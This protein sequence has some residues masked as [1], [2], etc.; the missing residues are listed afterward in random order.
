M[1]STASA[2]SSSPVRFALDDQGFSKALVNFYREFGGD[3]AKIIRAQARLISVNLV[4]QTQPF[5]GSR[6]TPGQQAGE[7][8]S[9]KKLGE[10]AIQRDINDLYTTPERI[11]YMIREMSLGAAKGFMAMVK[12][13][14]FLQAKALLDRLQISGLRSMDVGDFD[15]G[16]LHQARLRPVPGRPRIRKN[17]KPELIVPDQKSIDTY[18]KEIQKRVGMAKAGWAHCAQ[19]LGGTAG[20]TS[21]DV[22]GKQQVMV[23]RWVKKHAGNPSV[24]KVNDQSRARPNAYVEMTNTVPWIDKCLS[25]G[26]M[27]ASLDIQREKMETAIEKAAEYRARKFGEE[28]FGF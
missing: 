11:F 15:G 10:G 8:V 25:V 9:G 2:T 17:Q 23:P 7:Q 18:T 5:G 19:Q 16:A 3:L 6:P 22:A 24:G 1:I 14:R 20:Q 13:R 4:F 28:F 12:S 21:T 26:Q 27:Q